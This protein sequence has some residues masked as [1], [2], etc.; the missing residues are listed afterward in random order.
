MGET[1]GGIPHKQ[2]VTEVKKEHITN[3]WV[4]EV[5]GHFSRHNMLVSVAFCVR[6]RGPL[7]SRF[8]VI[9]DAVVCPH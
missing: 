1:M 3:S 5:D 6:D 4:P 8:D 2:Q 9:K 7:P